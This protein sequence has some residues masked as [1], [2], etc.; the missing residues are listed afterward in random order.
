MN[1][2]IQA[3]KHYQPQPVTI[4]NNPVCETSTSVAVSA[5]AK[6]TSVLHLING[7]HYSGAERVQDLLSANL[8]GLGYSVGFACLK[9]D[10][11]PKMRTDQNSVVH[12]LG[13]WNKF[14]L[15]AVFKVVGLVRRENYEL[16]HCHTPRTAMIGAMAAPIAGVPMIYHVH[17]PTS[18]DSDRPIANWVNTATER[19]SLSGVSQLICVS[20]SLA[21]H[22]QE[23][24]FTEDKISVVP[25]GVPVAASIPDRQAPSKVW[26]LG[27]V[28]LFRPRKGM[29]VLIDAIAL[30]KAEGIEV[31]LKAVGP[32]ETPEYE[33]QIKARAAD[34]N[35]TDL[36]E[37]VGFTREVNAELAKMD[38]FVLPSL[39]GEGLPM[40]V[41]EAMAM[42]VPVVGT[43][44]EGVPE[45]IR[46]NQD[47]VLAE[48]NDPADLAAAIARIING[49]VDWSAL[50]A[51]AISRQA[52]RFSDVSMAAGVA[53]AYRRCLG[54]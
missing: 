52:E 25:N 8:P 49:E 48:P 9:P 22:M 15:R 21:Q 5:P 13:M 3:A 44:V 28:A 4:M 24:G 17:S 16:I 42:G 38:L 26:T 33:Q 39:F 51:S 36:I 29:E 35:V 10:K 54:E 11:F 30:L 19:L 23:E 37:W 46:D 41:L 6:T 40:V 14:D 12:D 27:S 32:F 7:E 53:A 34:R 1:F 45:A 31:R 43:K 2:E 18:R 47:G 20:N 50:R